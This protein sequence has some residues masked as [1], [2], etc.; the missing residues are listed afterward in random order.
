MFQNFIVER[1]VQSTECIKI[2]TVMLFIEAV[3]DYWSL[4]F[5]MTHVCVTFSNISA[6]LPSSM[7]SSI[8]PSAKFTEPATITSLSG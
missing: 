2:E 7:R 5:G 8:L 1:T 3:M 4:L 6:I